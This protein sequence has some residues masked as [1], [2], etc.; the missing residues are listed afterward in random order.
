MIEVRTMSRMRGTW[1]TNEAIRGAKMEVI[2]G[3]RVYR[4][5]A[6]P[7]DRETLRDRHRPFTLAEHL[8]LARWAKQ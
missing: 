2:A 8:R 3:R 4:R 6:F 7:T 5:V 1:A